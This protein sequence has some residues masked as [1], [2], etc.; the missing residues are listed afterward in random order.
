[1]KRIMVL[2]A[3]GFEE[4]E[5]I[6]IL[7]V[8]RRAGLSVTAVGVGSKEIE[9]AHGIRFIADRLLSEVSSDD[10]DV[11]VLPGGQPGVDHLRA[12]ADVIKLLQAMEKKQKM[13]GAI[14]AAPI[15]LQ[16]AGIAK[17]KNLT[18]YPG[19]EKE[20]TESKF[21]EDRIVCDGNLVTSRGPGTAM[22]FSLKLVE[23][24]CGKEK[25]AQLSQGLLMPAA[26]AS[27]LR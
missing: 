11:L 14:C 21:H 3:A 6:T 22:E 15:V 18:C 19:F 16:R 2:F 25:A 4:I 8:L 13:I 20:L 27:S 10:A 24:L 12:S 5:G 1:M 26:V 7:D 9:G 17:G 23:I